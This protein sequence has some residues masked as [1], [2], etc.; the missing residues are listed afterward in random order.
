MLK[1][2][3]IYREFINLLW[4]VN[5]DYAISAGI[6]RNYFKTVSSM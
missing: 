6:F 2:M 1:H 4:G 5:E 3:V